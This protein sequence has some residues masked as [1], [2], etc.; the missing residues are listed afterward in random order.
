MELSAEQQHIF[1]YFKDGKNIFMTGPGGCGKSFIIKYIYNWCIENNKAV[2]VCALTGCAA[3]LLQTRAKTV[4]SWAGIGMANGN[5]GDIISRVVSSKYKKKNWKATNILIIDEISMMSVK[6]LEILD[7]I[8]KQVRKNNKPFGGIQLL[9]SGDFYQL[10]PVGDNNDPTTKQFCFESEIWN[11]L[12]HKELNLTKIF[13]QTD[14]SYTSI[15]NQIRKGKLRKSG[16]QQLQNRL[17]ACSDELLKPTKLMPR[18]YDVNKVNEIEL[19][20]ITSA[21]FTYEMTQVDTKMF[22][23]TEYQEYLLLRLPAQQIEYEV[24]YLKSSVMA[25]EEITLKVGAQV[26]CI[27]NL[28]LENEKPIANGSCGIISGFNN[29]LPIVKFKNGLSR[30]INYYVWESEHIKGVGIQQIPL[31][32]SWAITIHKAQGT[33]LE[34]AEIDIGSGI[35]E[36]GQSYVALSRVKDINGLFLTAFNQHNIKVSAKVTEYYNNRF[37]N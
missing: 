1:E 32:L 36:C 28:D 5:A 26:M 12:F 22:N 21:E 2:Q 31:I 27:V 25:E 4:H 20:K 11:T 10:P 35:F 14:E 8:G 23:L 7:T 30:T 3:I 15:L 19:K 33:T 37:N 34:L 24:E 9:F 6:L 18:R 17:V 29:N 13:R 16:L